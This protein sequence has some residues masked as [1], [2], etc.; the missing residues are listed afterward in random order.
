[1]FL[2]YLCSKFALRIIIIRLVTSIVG[3]YTLN[4]NIAD[5]W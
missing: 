5:E 3:I 2:T 1:M 4:T